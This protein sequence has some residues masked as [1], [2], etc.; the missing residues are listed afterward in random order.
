[1]SAVD[2]ARRARSMGDLPAGT[3]RWRRGA[4]RC[5]RRRCTARLSRGHR[6]VRLRCAPPTRPI[7]PT[8]ERPWPA[9]R[10]PTA[11]RRA[12]ATEP[13]TPTDRGR[14]PPTAPTT[15]TAAAAGADAAEP[16]RA[17]ARGTPARMGFA[18]AF[19]QSFRPL[20]VRADLAALPWIALHT[21]ALWLPVL[22]TSAAR[23]LIGRDRRRR[24]RSASSCSRTSSRRPAIGGVFIA[25]FLAPRASWL[26]GVDRRAR[27]RRSATSL[28]VV[29]FPATISPRRRRRRT[30]PAHRGL[31]RSSCSP[32]IGRV[33]RRRAR[34]GIAGSCGCRA[35]TA[36]G[37]ASRRRGRSSGQGD[38][39]TRGADASQKAGA[40]R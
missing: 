18:A 26:L 6:D 24:H 4:H 1:M 19:R 9:P 20:D 33:L 10:G 32:I 15:P 11:P 29:A 35:R 23:S 36:A 38:G 28:L 3:G 40:R 13:S 16:A 21:K 39:R 25:G 37:D 22:I 14:R 5:S 2:P 27:R 8:Q 31:A 12:A 17:A 34:P 30:R 7:R